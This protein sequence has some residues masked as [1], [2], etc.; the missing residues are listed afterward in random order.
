MAF[1]EA[2]AIVVTEYKDLAL[3]VVFKSKSWTLSF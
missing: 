1:D 3:A 2:V